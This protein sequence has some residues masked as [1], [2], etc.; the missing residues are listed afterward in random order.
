MNLSEIIIGVRKKI[1]PDSGHKEVKQSPYQQLEQQI[2]ENL[3]ATLERA[4]ETATIRGISI[5]RANQQEKLTQFVFRAFENAISQLQTL[6]LNHPHLIDTKTYVS[7]PGG[8]GMMI[9][10]CDNHSDKEKEKI[11]L[12]RLKEGTGNGDYTQLS[13]WAKLTEL[14]LTDKY[15]LDIELGPLSAIERTETGFRKIGL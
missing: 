9:D 10:L 3:L 13:K 4:K 14:D 1:M 15:S 12:K 5:F 8:H 6:L 7:G 2:W 11:R